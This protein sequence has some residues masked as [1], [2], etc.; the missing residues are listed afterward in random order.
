VT[1]FRSHGILLRFGIPSLDAL[2]GGVGD[3]PD[4][5]GIE[6]SS[7]NESTSISLIGPE[8]SGKS[9]FALHLVSRYLADVAPH[10]NTDARVLYV[11]TDLSHAR[12]CKIWHNFDLGWNC[13]RRD[14]F[15]RLYADN[16]QILTPLQLRSHKD[17]VSAWLLGT[18][19]AEVAFIDL[20][21]TTAGDDWGL[22]MRLVASLPKLTDAQHLIVIDALEGFETLTGE[23]DVFGETMSRRSRIAQ[24]MRLAAEKAHVV[25]VVE[26]GVRG[27]RLA[28]EF[29]TDA[30]IRLRSDVVRRY[31]RRT[32]EIE[33]VRAQ[34]HARGQH[35]I[36][37]RH[38]GGSTTGVGDELER[39]FKN[40]DDPK[41]TRYAK[42]PKSL[43]DKAF[44]YQSYVY[45]FHSLH[46]QSRRQMERRGETRSSRSGECA[47]FGIDYL[48]GMLAQ[49]SGGVSGLPVG[50]VTALIG[51]PDT[52]KT[53]LGLSFLADA[54]RPLVGPLRRAFMDVQKAA[55][56]QVPMNLREQLRVAAK[57]TFNRDASK[58]T[59]VLVT[60]RDTDAA[61]LAHVFAGWLFEDA[62]LADI[63]EQ[64][65]I[66]RIVCRRLETHDLPSAILFHIIRTAIAD[67]ENRM[68]GK[69][70]NGTLR[71]VI[72]DFSAW[73]EIYPEIQDEPLFLP[74]LLFY[75]RR[76][77]ATTLIID[78]HPGRPDTTITESFDRELRA[79]VDHQIYTWRVPFFGESRIAI[80]AIP[81]LSSSDPK[82]IVR[83]LKWNPLVVGGK[84]QRPQVDPH[85][86]LYSGLEEGR[87]EP[88]PL[89]VALFDEAPQFRTYI[90]QENVFYGN[91]FTGLMDGSAR[92]PVIHGVSAAE[93]ESLR[94]LGMESDTRLSHTLIFQVDEFWYERRFGT[95]HS[96]S[97]RGALRSQNEYLNAIA[98]KDGQAD[99]T[100]DAMGV[101]RPSRDSS[102][103]PA[104]EIRRADMFEEC[105]A[106]WQSELGS[107]TR[108]VDRVPFMWDFG[109]LLC[110]AKLFAALADRTVPFF[111]GSGRHTVGSIWARMSRAYG[112]GNELLGA[113]PS[114]K[115]GVGPRPTWR[116]FLGACTVI[117][118]AARDTGRILRPFD[119]SLT[120][121]ESLSCLILEIWASEMLAGL[122]DSQR[123]GFIN[124]LA[125]RK[126]NGIGGGLTEALREDATS[127]YKTW[128][129]LVDT[130]DLTS[131]ATSASPFEAAA[132][133]AATDCI[134]VRHWYKSACAVQNASKP[135]EPGATLPTGLPGSFSTR[136]D[137]FLAVANNSRSSGLA[138][139]ALDLLS[140]RRGN[141]TRMQLGLG[142]PTRKLTFADSCGQTSAGRHEQT[143]PLQQGDANAIRTALLAPIGDDRAAI[144]NVS[145]G[146]LRKLGAGHHFYWLWR[147]SI[148][149][150]DL[151][152][153]IWQ[154]WI[155]RV[156]VAWTELKADLGSDWQGGFAVY[157]H[158]L[159]HKITD[160][161]QFG[162][163]SSPEFKAWQA[164]HSETFKMFEVSAKGF[165]SLCD[166]L[167]GLIEAS[168]PVDTT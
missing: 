135:N 30:V 131:C 154:K 97:A 66:Q 139:R 110:Q 35:A 105:D 64:Q 39:Y 45:V 34:T 92:L 83:E 18:L 51:Q 116:E 60:T 112:R 115:G 133:D 132:R 168:G 53:H 72:E 157:D 17:P 23:R 44:P 128:L 167:I 102:L 88:V 59:A 143:F 87:P 14:P 69:G 26:E 122:A 41:L 91:R 24:L 75:L 165:L 107:G 81:P 95:G 156:V 89:R 36:T 104:R 117:S 99:V 142:L 37:I 56:T 43:S 22:I 70:P 78:T 119:L 2:L 61:E 28:E 90:D 74:F 106:G 4:S 164:Q 158:M 147:S 166:L 108:T 84:P 50:S 29:V 155:A 127:L 21:Q 130:L 149:H 11:S 25:F 40:R 55:Q 49:S 137:W 32:V 47:G 20:A 68:L 163:V 16:T 103:P 152:N 5:C 3:N 77:K 52:Q 129:L 19:T 79:L 27:A 10:G 100:V 76:Q 162:E 48:D 71:L 121:A 111:A 46:H 93:Y 9:I 161:R 113:R 141:F 126:S 140:S 160:I 144:G 80:S 58:G 136:G 8:G 13:P 159:Q 125:S 7:R 101:F 148:S 145:Y 109:F 146:E 31:T 85:F 94:S 38:G 57:E 118:D 96:T 12:A 6:L 123:I 42:R 62:C 33:K 15:S 1:T 82:A 124:R 54:F 73:K 63:V 138:D 67:A 150:Y 153:R 98:W 134:A 114:D 120:T 151:V 65:I 86:E